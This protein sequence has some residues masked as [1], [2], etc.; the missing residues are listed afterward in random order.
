MLSDLLSST[1]RQHL[2]CE[3]S[4]WTLKCKLRSGEDEVAMQKIRAVQ[5]KKGVL[6]ENCA[7]PFDLGKDEVLDTACLLLR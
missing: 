7:F 5:G 2:Y 1:L 3:C 4:I 6:S